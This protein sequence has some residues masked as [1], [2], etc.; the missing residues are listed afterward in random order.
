MKCIAKIDRTSG[1]AHQTGKRVWLARLMLGKVGTWTELTLNFYSTEALCKP[2]CN[3]SSSF[4]TILNSPLEPPVIR[5]C[6]HLIVLRNLTGRGTLFFPL[7]MEGTL[8]VG[9]TLF[10][11]L[12]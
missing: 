12:R 4:S 3:G 10:F 11:L 9:G 6:R 1:H 8:S 2:T 7:I 5:N